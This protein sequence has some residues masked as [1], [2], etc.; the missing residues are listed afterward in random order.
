VSL[1]GGARWELAL[2]HQSYSRLREMTVLCKRARMSMADNPASA[3]LRR[4]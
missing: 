3:H 2:N 1:A 4:L